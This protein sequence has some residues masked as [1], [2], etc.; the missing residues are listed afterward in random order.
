MPYELFAPL[1]VLGE[2]RSGIIGG[3]AHPLLDPAGRL[4]P[5]AGDG[6]PTSVALTSVIA[7]ALRAP[8]DQAQVMFDSRKSVVALLGTQTRIV[9]LASSSGANRFAGEIRLAW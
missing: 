7:G 1:S 9:L 5:A 3:A 8:G 2:V 6:P 4:V